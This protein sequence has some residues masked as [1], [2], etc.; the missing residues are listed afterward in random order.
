M[1]FLSSSTE[2]KGWKNLL[3]A[4]LYR[5]ISSGKQRIVPVMLEEC[6]PPALIAGYARIDAG[7]VPSKIATELEEAIFRKT[8]K[9]RVRC[10]AV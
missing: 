3:N 9:P 6:T 7:R 10:S 1:I 2:P 4:S 8:A 5:A